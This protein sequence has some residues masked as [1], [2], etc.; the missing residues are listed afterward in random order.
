MAS[1]LQQLEVPLKRVRTRLVC[2]KLGQ[3]KY[4]RFLLACSLLQLVLFGQ[5]VIPPPFPVGPSE[6]DAVYKFTPLIFSMTSMLNNMVFSFRQ[7]YKQNLH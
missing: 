6:Q 1:R 5:T 3:L 4:A 7:K 2:K